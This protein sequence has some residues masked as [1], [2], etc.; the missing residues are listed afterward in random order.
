M[1]NNEAERKREKRGRRERKKA[2]RGV[3]PQNN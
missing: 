2:A 1:I 3:E